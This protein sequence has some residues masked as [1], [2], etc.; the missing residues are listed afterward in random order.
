MNLTLQQLSVFERFVRTGGL[1]NAAE[2][3]RMS[4]EEIAKH[5]YDLEKNI[6]LPLV[7]THQQKARVT[8]AGKEVLICAESID[9]PM[10]AL[11]GAIK[12]IKNLERGRLNI[13]IPEEA[14]DVMPKLLSTFNRVH[15]DIE[16]HLNV[17]ERNE[18]IT[19][20]NSGKIDIAVMDRDVSEID[21]GISSSPLTQQW[22]NVFRNDQPRSP[23][24]RSFCDF[25]TRN[26]KNSANPDL[27]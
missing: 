1:K 11:K 27:D 17:C 7:T 24:A 23:A 14:H 9:I 15:E 12:E 8:E 16:I 6:G 3:A 26:A 18:L 4:E 22:R 19:Q 5:L 10:R 25:A 21:D 2:D 13:V 20:L